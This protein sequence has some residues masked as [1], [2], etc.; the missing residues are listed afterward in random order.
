VIYY[1]QLVHTINNGDEQ[2]TYKHQKQ[3]PFQ[4]SSRPCRTSGII[5]SKNFKLRHLE[6][7]LT[8]FCRSTCG[9]DVEVCFFFLFIHPTSTDKTYGQE[10][11]TEVYNG[12]V[13]MSS[14][15][16]PGTAQDDLASSSSSSSWEKNIEARI[17]VATGQT[18]PSCHWE[19]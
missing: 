15:F 11:S 9:Y 3:R 19:S 6:H 7:L 17:A 12:D 1:Y 14:L 10:V 18:H 8:A 16:C 13:N 4:P 2:A 5:I